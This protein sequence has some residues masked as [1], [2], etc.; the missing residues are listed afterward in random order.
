MGWISETVLFL[1]DDDKQP[2][3]THTSTNGNTHG[4]THTKKSK[5]EGPCCCIWKPCDDE[6]VTNNRDNWCSCCCLWMPLDDMNTDERKYG[7]PWDWFC[8]S[9][10]DEQ[11]NHTKWWRRWCCTRWLFEDRKTEKNTT[12]KTGTDTPQWCTCS[13]IW[14]FFG[15]VFKCRCKCWTCCG[16][17]GISKDCDNCLINLSHCCCEC[18]FGDED[19]KNK[20]L[21]HHH[22]LNLRRT[23]ASKYGGFIY[24]NLDRIGVYLLLCASLWCA[25]VVFFEEI[26]LGYATA[27][28]GNSCPT[29]KRGT[30]ST[31]VDCFI[32]KNAFDVNPIN[33]SFPTQ[34]NS[35]MSIIFTGYSASC[36]AWI[37]AN[38]EVA[39]V[40]EELGICA[41]IVALLGS[42]VAIMGYLCRKHRW[43][44][45]FD[46]IAVSAVAAIPSLIYRKGDVPF[47]TH[48]LLGSLCAVI[49]ITQYLLH[50]VPFLTWL[51]LLNRIFRCIKYRNKSNTSIR[52]TSWD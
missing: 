19:L 36:F 47:M 6:M 8:R 30:P 15:K 48:I 46:M 23:A 50:Y 42:V 2:K 4:N 41:G 26:I 11:N 45:I 17:N 31:I 21:P 44:I 27:N 3:I 20:L 13:Y 7:F 52:V 22:Y 34:C 10:D 16:C 35:S 1:K 25:A 5:N 51:C 49:A 33:T 14:E 12:K 18:D 43:R 28:S 32:F 37:Y 39:D 29:P 9:S 24:L 40:I 38:V